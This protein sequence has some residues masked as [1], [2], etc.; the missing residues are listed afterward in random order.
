MPKKKILFL[1]GSPNQTTQM[2]QVSAELQDYDCFFSQLYS[3]SPMV[4]LAGKRGL[5]DT[6]IL[7]GEF[8]RKAAAYLEDNSL[9]NDYASSVYNNRYDMAVFCSDLIVTKKLRALKTVWVQEG[10]TDPLTSWG[11]IVRKL[12][13][14]GYWAM[15]TA[16][17]GSSN[18]CDIY[19]AASQGYKDQFS[20]MGT[21]ADKIFVTGIPNYDN[22]KAFLNNDFPHRNYVLVATSDIRETFNKDDREAF[23]ANCVKIAAGRQL[24]F[25]LHPNEVK[26]RAVAEIKKFAPANALIYTDGNTSHMVANCEELI[27]QYSTVVY[28]GIGLG[29]K[30]HSYFDVEN[31]K[32]LSPLQNGGT[33]AA[34]IAHICRS[35]IEFKGNRTEFLRSYKLPKLQPVK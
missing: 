15:N 29:K 35:Y 20:L 33:S 23:I 4:K 11:K 18:I 14:P 27:T 21:Q 6:T 9:R 2:H 5:L 16:L 19:C 31:L 10:M 1:I 22:V 8:K 30:V 25:K 28:I 17:N 34:N 32:K 26:E 12:N 24:I 3:D 13:L 7:G